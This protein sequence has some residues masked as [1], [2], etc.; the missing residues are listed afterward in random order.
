MSSTNHRP[1]LTGTNVAIIVGTLTREP[2]HR[3]LPSGDH[4]LVLDVTVR[5]PGAAAES[6]PVAWPSG[7]PE[8]T[9]WDVGMEVVVVGRVRRRFFRSG[10]ATQSRTEVVAS[11]VAPTRRTASARRIVRR[12][13]DDLAPASA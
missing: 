10:G 3:T 7:A 4:L 8:A 2:E 12:A 6:V 11:A 5:P 1:A 9:S 13:L